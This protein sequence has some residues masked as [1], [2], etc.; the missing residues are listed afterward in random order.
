M[1]AKFSISHI[2]IGLTMLATAG[3]ALAIKP[4]ESLSDRYGKVDLEV[5]IPKQFGGW[6]IEKTAAPLVS[7]EVK[8]AVDKVYAQTLS[9][10]YVNANGERIMLSIAYGKNQN[11]SLAIH[12]PEGCYGGQGF[13]IQNKVKGLLQTNYGNIPVARLYATKEDRYE[14]ITYWITVG[15][16]PVYDGW[17]MKKLKLSYALKGLIPDGML[18]RISN[19]NLDQTTPAQVGYDLQ[20]RFAEDLLTHI[21]PKQRMHLIGLAQ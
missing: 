6:A 12:L 15:E 4:S 9:R 17:D 18:V 14:P 16:H 13:A 7:P 10:N 1:N 20:A 5:I 3:L 21:S 8:D 2:I 19:I 11:D